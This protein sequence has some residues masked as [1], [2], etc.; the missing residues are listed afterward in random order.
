MSTTIN[1]S[2]LLI[3]EQPLQLLPSLAIKL[4]DIHEAIV[5]Q[6]LQNKLR[7]ANKEIEGQKWVCVEFQDWKEIFPWLPGKDIKAF[8]ASLKKKH[9]IVSSEINQKSWYS[10]DYDLLNDFLEN[11]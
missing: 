4:G 3:N 11:K 1:S 9:I 8:L 5:L 10:I 7:K 6:A 2:P